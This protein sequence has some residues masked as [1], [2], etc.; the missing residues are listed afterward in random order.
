[1]NLAEFLKCLAEGTV[2]SWAYEEGGGNR[3]FAPLEI[4][5]KNPNFLENLKSVA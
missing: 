1:V 3:A 5:T 4:W 2:H